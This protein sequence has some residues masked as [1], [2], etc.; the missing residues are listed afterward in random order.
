M[1]IR[2]TIAILALIGGI[3]GVSFAQEKVDESYRAFGVAMGPGMAGVLDLHI[4]R[5]STPEE[6]QALIDS[7]VQSGQEK[8]VELLRKQKE[9]GWARTQSGPECTAGRAYVSITPT[10]SRS[11]M[12]SVSWSW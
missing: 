8:T 11:R 5:W 12:E 6:R 10:S 7:L 4:S 3:A 9:T 2:R 1:S